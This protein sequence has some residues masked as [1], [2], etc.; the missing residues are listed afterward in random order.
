MSTEIDDAVTMKAVTKDSEVP[1]PSSKAG[2]KVR[3]KIS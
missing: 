3:E 1:V 2:C